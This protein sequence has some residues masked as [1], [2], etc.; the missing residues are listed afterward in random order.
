MIVRRD[1]DRFAAG[2]SMTSLRSSAIRR[3]LLFLLTLVVAP[4]CLVLSVSPAYDDESIAWD[5][6]L[7]GAWED[8]DDK[9]SIQ[10]ERG[11]WKSYKIHY[12]YTIE[13]GDVTGYLTTIGDQRYLDVTTARGE[14][15][16]SFLIPVHAILRVRLEGDTLQLTPLSYDWFYDRISHQKAVPG[17]PA[18][19]DQKQN[20]LIVASTAALRAW[21]KPQVPDGPM[22]GAAATFV[23][24]AESGQPEANTEEPKASRR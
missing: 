5:P 14:D 18:V 16:G 7:V 24:K 10:V 20:A 13:T 3:T 23:R 6:G 4:G 17:L 12:T 21:I 9:A 11:E 15:R 22:F 1:C 2:A 19:L 8:L